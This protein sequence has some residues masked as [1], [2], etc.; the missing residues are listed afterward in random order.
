VDVP[1][2]IDFVT[3]GVRDVERLRR[4]YAGWGWI[5]R[6]GGDADFAQFQLDGM[7]FALY[8]LD[9]LRDEAAGELPVRGAWSG[10]TL[11]VNVGSAEQVRDV[12]RTAVA[13][14]ATPVTEPVAREWGGVSGYLAD[15]E[16][17]RWEIAWLPGFRED[18]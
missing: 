2:R 10:V 1:A 15:P 18:R 6:P 7:R 8:R 12:F 16:G 3:L 13:A 14:G 9:L 5:E 4:F 17:H 11:S